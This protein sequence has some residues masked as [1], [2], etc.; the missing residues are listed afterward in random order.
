MQVPYGLPE[1]PGVIQ[2]AGQAFGV[3][4]RSIF[5]CSYQS[6]LPKSSCPYMDY[7]LCKGEA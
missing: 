7:L 5:L 4:Q 1:A 2:K 6:M 3:S